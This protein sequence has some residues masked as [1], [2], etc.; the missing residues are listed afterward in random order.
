MGARS[1]RYGTPALAAIATPVTATTVAAQPATPA[2]AAERG[3]RPHDCRP[4]YPAAAMR[5]KVEGM[6]R[7]RLDVDA[8]GHVAAAVAQSAGPTPEHKLLDEAA[9]QALAHCPITPGRDAHGK[10]VSASMNVDYFWRLDPPARPVS[11]EIVASAA[12][13]NKQGDSR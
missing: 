2:S 12:A 6:T 13:S 1:K 8:E 4:T 9:V 3:D 11:T 5:A 10:P 7:V